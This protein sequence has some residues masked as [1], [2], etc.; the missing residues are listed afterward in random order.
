MFGAILLAVVAVA[1]TVV[2]GPTIIGAA[3]S[4]LG[5]VGG[6]VVGGAVTG[7]LGS[8]ASQA[9]GNVTGI[10]DGFSFRALRLPRWRAGSAAGW[11]QS[12]GSPGIGGG[13]TNLAAGSTFL[14]NAARARSATR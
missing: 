5:A 12:R 6:A 4:L 2:A 9:V 11:A 3:S 10:Q 7:A 8:I 1:V 14:Q 13:A